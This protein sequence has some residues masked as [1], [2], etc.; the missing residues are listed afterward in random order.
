M[1]AV[2]FL[3]AKN[4]EKQNLYRNYSASLLTAYVLFQFVTNIWTLPYVILLHLAA[5]WKYFL[6]IRTNSLSFLKVISNSR[7]PSFYFWQSKLILCINVSN[8][9][10]FSNES[11]QEINF[12]F[13]SMKQRGLPWLHVKITSSLPLRS[14]KGH[15]LLFYEEGQRLRCYGE[16]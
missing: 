12:L 3:N 16:P 2:E 15:P 4:R 11:L 8:S 5:I 7:N 9:E 1:L 13:Q 10:R 6:P 14:T